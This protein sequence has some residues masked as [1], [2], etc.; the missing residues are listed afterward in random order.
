MQIIDEPTRE[1]NTLDLIFTNELD[2][3]SHMDINHSTLSDHHLMELTSTFKTER[4]EETLNLNAENHG[5]R[6]YNFFSK[7][8]K[9]KEIKNEL[10]DKNWEELFKDKNTCECTEILNRIVN[11]VCIKYVPLKG[12][13]RLIGRL[14][15]LKKGKKEAFSN[16][17]IENLDKKIM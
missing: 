1:K 5:L 14:K 13:K 16:E 17:K 15:M 7:K 2:I 8:A 3:F 4:F 11:E 9:W 6:N 10:N 12:A